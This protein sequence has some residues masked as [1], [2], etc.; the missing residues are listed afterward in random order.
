MIQ[1]AFGKIT[2]EV[3]RKEWDSEKIIAKVLVRGNRGLS[4]D[5]TKKK[6]DI[7]EKCDKNRR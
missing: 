6:D 3:R 2:L 1:A 5:D 4:Q 7:I